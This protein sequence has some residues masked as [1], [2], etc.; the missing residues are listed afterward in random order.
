MLNWNHLRLFEAAARSGSITRAAQ[1]LRLSQPAVSKQVGEL[2]RGLGVTL[3]ER[4]PRGVRPTAA[5]AVLA[6]YARRLFGLAEEAER[7]LG[8]MQQLRRGRLRIGASTTIGVY[9]AP[10]L[11]AA[12]RRQHP[13]LELEFLIGNT[14]TVQKRL[15]ERELDLG[16]TEGP[17]HWERELEGEVFRWDELI[18]IA[19]PGDGPAADLARAAWVMR[20]PGSG[21]RA[22]V[23]AA[24]AA[25]GLRV[26]PV[27][28]FNNPEA[29]K[30]AV[31]AG[32]GIAMVPRI[33]VEAELAARTLR[34][35][36]APGLE[37]R[38]PLRL[39]WRKGMPVSA[40]LAAFQSLC[41]RPTRAD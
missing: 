41:R 35:L 19:A 40:A 29:V 37:R 34:R 33:T 16:L 27:W 26:S 32:C 24:L 36:R 20:E 9:L 31:M 39:Q 28:T 5:G 23:D 14:D 38:R 17:G 15:V 8:E 12:F 6:E 7:A 22:V 10:P 21:T 4:A 25:R 1:E 30:R 11:L 18:V 13:E 2:E 3:L